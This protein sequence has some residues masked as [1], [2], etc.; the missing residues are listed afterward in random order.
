MAADIGMSLK[1]RMEVGDGKTRTKKNAIE[2]LQKQ[3]RKNPEGATGPVISL[4]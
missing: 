4:S 3:D 1:E 2:Q